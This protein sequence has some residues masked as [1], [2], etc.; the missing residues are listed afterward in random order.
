MDTRNMTDRIW[1]IVVGLLAVLMV[2]GAVRVIAAEVDQ[3]YGAA[4]EALNRAAY[5]EAIELYKQAYEADLAGDLASKALY[6]RA[7]AHY[8]LGDKQ[9]LK[10]ALQVLELQRSRFP[11]APN[12]AEAEAL[13]AHVTGSLARH[14]DARAVRRVR[15]TARGYIIESGRSRQTQDHEYEA[16]VA[17]LNALMMMDAERA[18]PILEKLLGDEDTEPELKR[19]ALMV[20]AQ[21]DDEAAER[22]L[23]EVVSHETD[24]EMLAQSLFWLA[25]ME[26]DAALD[27]VLA[28]YRRTEDDEVKQAALMAMSQNH[29]R[30]AGDLLLEVARDVTSG[31]ELRSQAVYALAQVHVEGTAEIF[32]DLYASSDDSEFKSMIMYAMTDL[33]HPASEDWFERIITDPH[34][35]VEV[36]QQGLHYA[37]QMDMLDTTFLRKVYRSDND[38]EMRTQVCYVLSQ[39]DDP[40]AVDLAIEIVREEDDPEVRHQAIYWLGQFEDPRIVDFL[41]ELIEED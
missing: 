16:R 14:G 1:L 3:T 5:A 36:R 35:S 22:I 25:Q 24:Q 12:L 11:Q 28:A 19:H 2:A 29:D 26:S 20:L 17:A 39:I 33:D 37:G 31:T 10:R 40:D 32:M 21:V 6:W 30:R 18:L 8:K 9:H 4:Q 41:V 7:Y 13:Y 38:P 34:E 23:I 15:E 27:A